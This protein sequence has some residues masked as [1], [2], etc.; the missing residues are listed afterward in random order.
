MLKWHTI[1]ACTSGRHW[2]SGAHGRLLQ[3]L[4]YVAGYKGDQGLAIEYLT[5]SL[6]IGE[7][8]GDSSVIARA[9]GN[10]GVC[11]FDQKEYD[12][13]LDYFHLRIAVADAIGDNNAPG[14]LHLHRYVARRAA[15]GLARKG[16]INC[17]RL[18][19]EI[20]MTQQS[21]LPLTPWAPG[22]WPRATTNVASLIW[23]QP[24]RHGT[25]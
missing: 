2:A 5:N 14:G 8:L 25:W 19:R 22:M 20:F 6:R 9:L 3:Q 16:Y 12:V 18:A 4:G 10:I 23:I 24:D 11:H 21:P 13:A 7:E 17:L 1:A 15:R